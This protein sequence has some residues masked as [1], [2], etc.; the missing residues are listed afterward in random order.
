MGSNV[1]SRK[2]GEELVSKMKLETWRI[3]AI[4]FIILFVL[5]TSLF[6]YG[7]ITIV[8]EEKQT[9]DCYY[10]F[11]SENYYADYLD[12]VCT[13]YD[14]DLMGDYFVAKTKYMK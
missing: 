7:W 2:S 12:G 6:V 11:C 4:I 5:E 10:N 13:C 1:F 9:Y 3:I 14:L 8:E